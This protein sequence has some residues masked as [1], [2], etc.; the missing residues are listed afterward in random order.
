MLTRVQNNHC[1][2][3]LLMKRGERGF[4]SDY[5]KVLMSPPDH[6]DERAAAYLLV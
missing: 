5:T 1:F 3:R 4:I 2:K 6:L